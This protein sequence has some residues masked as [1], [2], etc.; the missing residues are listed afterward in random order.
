MSNAPN[1]PR[2]A[3]IE[4]Q[5]EAALSASRGDRDR[6]LE[7]M[8]ALEDAVGQ[9]G[10]GRDQAW[11]EA[12]AAALV[13]LQ[14]ALAEQQASYENPTSLMAQI[15]QDDP[16]LRTWVRQLHHRWNDLATTTQTLTE[17]RQADDI[18]DPAAITDMREQVRWLM[19]SLHHHRAREADLIFEGLGIDIAAA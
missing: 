12:A 10:R 16:R 14:N 13:T 8:R 2:P 4:P 5:Q 17:A 3:R 15:A 18:G 6:A 9:A 11:R 7:A 1:Q 19:T